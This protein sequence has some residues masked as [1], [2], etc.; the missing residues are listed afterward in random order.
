MSN[1]P[2]PNKAERSLP[3]FVRNNWLFLSGTLL[4]LIYNAV[5]ILSSNQ[6]DTLVAI[7]QLRT[8]GWDVFFKVST[9]F[10]EPVAY[11]GVLLLV[12]AFSYR[13]AIFVVV[14]GATAGIVSGVLKAL[15]S[16]ARPMRWF[17]D[18]YEEI[19]HSL[20]HFEEEW[21]SWDAASSFPSGHATSAFALYGFLAFNARWRKNYVQAF[22][23][24]LAVMVAFSRMYLLYH[25]LRDVTVGAA[26]G[27]TIGALVYYLQ[28][29][30][31]RWPGLDRGWWKNGQEAGSQK[32]G[33]AL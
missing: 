33:I 29:S 7:N 8:P 28:Q 25:F 24:F 20:N 2:P 15:F 4:L 11:A 21:R 6:G 12:S 10:A 22:C 16:Q 18:N 19:W 23:L 9:H 3:R 27:T 13:K 17:F 26:L 5:M 31:D 30:N 32:S 14:A 1:L